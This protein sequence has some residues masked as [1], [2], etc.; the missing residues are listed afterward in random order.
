MAFAGL[1]RSAFCALL[2]CGE[3]GTVVSLDCSMQLSDPIPVSILRSI[4]YV[5]LVGVVMAYLGSY[6]DN[7]DTDAVPRLPGSASSLLL[8]VPI[9]TP[10]KHYIEKALCG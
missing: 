4:S 6:D 5:S 10:K 1:L 9:K 8:F 3:V 7:Q 2:A